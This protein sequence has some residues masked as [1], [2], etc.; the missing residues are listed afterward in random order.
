MD[1]ITPISNNRW[2][3]WSGLYALAVIL[4][5]GYLNFVTPYSAG[6]TTSPGFV[7]WLIWGLLYLPLIALPLMA[8]WN[9]SELGF[10]LNPILLL[11]FFLIIS[12]CFFVTQA[13][14][15]NW[16]A[17]GIEA[18][19][20]TGEEFFFRGFLFAFFMVL[21]RSKRWPW[22]WA[23]LLSSL[24]FTV[25]H[26]QTFQPVMLRQL[27][28]PQTP[29]AVVI[30]D[31]FFNLF[32]AALAIACLRA[33]T[34]SILPGA[35]IHSMINGAGILAVPFVLVIYGAGLLWAYC[36]GEKV[37]FGFDKVGEQKG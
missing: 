31:R 27:G 9:I 10:T 13:N 11:I 28:W 35:I 24:L 33:W 20:R 23:A 1:A 14:R 32:T 30:V 17:A 12:V 21:F 5:G 37:V 29:L 18:F 22:L 36:R 7:G 3:V 16:A 2:L 4:L 26:T 34:R 6:P 8:K 19:A 15:V 25:V